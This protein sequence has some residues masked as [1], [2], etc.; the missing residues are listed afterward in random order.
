M[1]VTAHSVYCVSWTTGW[2]V[3]SPPTISFWSWISGCCLQWVP[4]NVPKENIPV[5]TP[6]SLSFS[7]SWAGNVVLYIEQP[8]GWFYTNTMR[9]RDNKYCS[10]AASI[11]LGLTA[12]VKEQT[13]IHSKLHSSHFFN[14]CPA[15]E[16]LPGLCC[17]CSQLLASSFSWGDSEMCQEESDHWR[18]GWD[19][20]PSS[21]VVLLAGPLIPKDRGLREQSRNRV[22]E[23]LLKSNSFSRSTDAVTAEAGNWHFTNTMSKWI[24]HSYNLQSDKNDE[25]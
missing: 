4:S 1:T 14:E 17:Y 5:F 18:S 22:L 2:M 6:I 10:A 24:I 8:L 23:S 12:C 7:A 20:T 3:K 11:T 25:W 19:W 21:F 16:G 15:S 9:L 13:F